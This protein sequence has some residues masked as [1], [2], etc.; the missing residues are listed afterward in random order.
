[1]HTIRNALLVCSSHLAPHLPPASD[2]T[3]SLAHWRPHLHS[4]EAV[5]AL[6]AAEAAKTTQPTPSTTPQPTNGTERGSPLQNNTSQQQSVDREADATMAR[7]QSRVWSH[8]PYAPLAQQHQQD[9]EAGGVNDDVVRT[10]LQQADRHGGEAARN[11]LCYMLAASGLAS[12]ALGRMLAMNVPALRERAVALGFD[13]GHN[14]AAEAVQKIGLPVTLYAPHHPNGPAY[15]WGDLVD[16]VAIV[17]AAPGNA[18]P[19]AFGD[20]HFVIGAIFVGNYDEHGSAMGGHYTVTRLLH[21]RTALGVY[22][23]VQRPQ[24]MLRL[25]PQAEEP[26]PTSTTTAP[27]EGVTQHT[28]PPATNATARPPDPPATS[29]SARPPNTLSHGYVRRF[30]RHLEDGARIRVAWILGEEAGTWCGEVVSRGARGVDP[31]CAYSRESCQ[32]CGEWRALPD[33]IELDLPHDGVRYLEVTELDGEMPHTNCV[34]ADDDEDEAADPRGEIQPTQSSTMAEL[35]S[36]AHADANADDPF[37]ADHGCANLGFLGSPP[38]NNAPRGNVGRGWFLHNGRPASVHPIVWRQLAATTR[39]THIRWLQ[40]LRGLPQDLG[41]APLGAAI[42]EIVMRMGT[43]RSWKWSTVSSALSSVASALASLP[44]YS[45]ATAAIDVRSDPIF[46]A[47]AKRAQHLA[48]V[49]S[50][51]PPNSAL[52]LADFRAARDSLNDPHARLLLQLMWC[53]ASRPADTRQV[54]ANDAHIVVIDEAVAEVT[55]TFR[56]GKG[57]AFW[58]PFSVV[59]RAPT[60]LAQALADACAASRGGPL[61]SE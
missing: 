27:V 40:L 8:Q 19:A 15:L 6:F 52:P 57:A 32:L 25:A 46:A 45:N 21:P 11:A 59:A 4:H 18:L 29:A 3:L 1:M 13:D 37:A 26:Q 49:A 7:Q 61:F 48:R 47:A 31:I 17:R 12:V 20:H 38:H 35:L 41:D 36:R 44:I 14:D 24:R 23:H 16:D 9:I 28:N 10:V 54:R 53:F 55:L 42:V 33:P 50:R 43:A 2:E 60:E 56:F 22:A 30:A 34:C 58:G 5:S 39:A 51:A